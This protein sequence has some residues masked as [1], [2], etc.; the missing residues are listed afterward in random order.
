MSG[1]FAGIVKFDLAARN[2][3]AVVGH[4]EHGPD[5]FGGEAVFVP[6]GSDGAGVGT[7]SHARM[8]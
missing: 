2:G 3:S 8:R 4:I 5:C 6:A 1:K 7:C